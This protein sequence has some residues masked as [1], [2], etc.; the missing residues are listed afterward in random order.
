MSVKAENLTYYYMKGTP[1]ESLAIENIS[2]EIEQGEFVGIIGHTGSGKSTLIQQLDGLLVPTSGKV[3]VD[4][5]GVNS[6]KKDLKEI[7]RRVGIV[8]QYPEYQLFEETVEKDVAYGPKN[9]GFDDET[10]N[11]RVREAI[12]DMGLDFDE[13]KDQSPF[14][15]S[16][17][18][19]RR[20]AIAGVLAMNP[21][22]IIFDEPTAG[23]DPEGRELLFERIKE[24][25]KKGKTVIL[26]SHSMD[27]IAKLAD[28][29]LVLSEGR[30]VFDG[31]PGEVF[32][33]TTKIKDLDVPQL[34]TLSRMLND[35]GLFSVSEDIFNIED[36]TKAIL[37]ALGRCDNV[38]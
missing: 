24:I 15:L 6:N 34:T 3:T 25:R 14:E 7:R 36:M 4:G 30:L 17:G 19:K 21:E 13:I 22:I 28:R 23:L 26:V 10:V 37:D 12:T 2:F 35:S 27:D 20:V 8:F 18:Q 33:R 32:S 16:G 11:R 1:F 9:L 5:F 31:T 29:I 38:Q